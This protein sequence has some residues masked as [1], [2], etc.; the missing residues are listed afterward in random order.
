MDWVSTS[1]IV[2]ATGLG[3]ILIGIFGLLSHRNILRI[4]VSIGLV[5]TGIAMLMVAIGYVT[6]GTAPI[7]DDALPVSEAVNATVDP[8]PSALTVTAI[9]I[10]LSVT[11]ILLAYAIRLFEARGTLNIDAFKDS[12]W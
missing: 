2:L 10:G 4:I 7:I 8:L 12:K 3:L 6:D 11:A 1:S 5:D 9:V